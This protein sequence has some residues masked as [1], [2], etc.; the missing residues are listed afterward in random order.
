M[1]RTRF[2]HR[3]WHPLGLS[4]LKVQNKS[5]ELSVLTPDAESASGNSGSKF[6]EQSQPGALINDSSSCLRRSGHQY[7]VADGQDGIHMVPNQGEPCRTHA[8]LSSKA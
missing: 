8:Q 3:K 7:G 1:L 2:Q 4:C 5:V 6:S